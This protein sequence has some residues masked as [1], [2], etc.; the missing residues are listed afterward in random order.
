MHTYAPNR[1]KIW[2]RRHWWDSYY[3]SY[4][5]I[6]M[7]GP[8]LQYILHA[9]TVT[10]AGQHTTRP[11]DINT[12]R[13]ALLLVISVCR[14]QYVFVYLRRW[15]NKVHQVFRAENQKQVLNR[16][17]YLLIPYWYT[18]IR[19]PAIIIINYPIQC[20]AIGCMRC[21]ESSALSSHNMG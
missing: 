4:K 16:C 11:A 21:L 1:K 5:L 10:D 9:H 2:R 17:R 13:V 12:Q 14:Q 15:A 3:R 7:L 18:R 19:I 20:Q 8:W 6:N